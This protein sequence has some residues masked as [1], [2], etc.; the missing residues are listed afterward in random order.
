M[1]ILAEHFQDFV[2]EFVLTYDPKTDHFN[3][4]YSLAW[5]DDDERLYVNSHSAFAEPIIW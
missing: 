5:A 4:L 3:G 2:D 1:D